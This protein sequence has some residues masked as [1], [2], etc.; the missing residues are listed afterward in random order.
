MSQTQVK[1]RSL[2]DLNVVTNV[3]ISKINWGESAINICFDV[4]KNL[5]RQAE[6][7]R[8]TG[9]LEREY[10]ALMKFARYIKYNEQCLAL[11]VFQLVLMENFKVPKIMCFFFNLYEQLLK[12]CSNK[13]PPTVFQSTTLTL[14]VN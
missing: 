13:F 12:F 1:Y 4:A 9:D 6:V 2:E 10:I 7:F 3:L 14:Y 11:A 8:R 5:L